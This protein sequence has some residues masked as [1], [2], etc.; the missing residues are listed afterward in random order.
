MV[1]C[2]PIWHNPVGVCIS[3]A[4]A[5]ALLRLCAAHGVAVLADEA[6]EA[7]GSGPLAQGVSLA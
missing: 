5:A 1:Y 4:R 2:Q 6:Y 7:Y 3:A